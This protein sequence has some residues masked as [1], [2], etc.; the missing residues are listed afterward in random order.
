M[1]K[2]YRSFMRL[3]LILIIAYCGNNSQAQIK[4]S[5]LNCPDKFRLTDDSLKVKVRFKNLTNK[6]FLLFY[7]QNPLP[8]N[9]PADFFQGQPSP[10]TSFVTFIDGQQL[11]AKQKIQF[12]YKQV[13][14]LDF[15][16]EKKFSEEQTK[17]MNLQDSLIKSRIRIA[18]KHPII[19]QARGHTDIEYTVNAIELILHSGDYK[20]AI[21]YQCDTFLRFKKTVL[22]SIKSHYEKAELFL[23][24][25]QSN[26]VK[27]MIVDTK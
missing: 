13:Q 16:E 2:N 24:K 22:D 11:I 15:E 10:P 9:N 20:I 3:L 5:I 17:L 19:L 7:T 12:N 6:D 23:G 18:V 4:L 25:I 26:P 27:I 21:G 8:Y 1:N 14:F